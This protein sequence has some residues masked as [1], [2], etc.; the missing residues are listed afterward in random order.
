MATYNDLKTRAEFLVDDTIDNIAMWFNECLEDLSDISGFQKTLVFDKTESDST[1]YGGY[2]FSLPSDFIEVAEIV[3]LETNSTTIKANKTFTNKYALSAMS[4][5]TTELQ[6]YQVTQDE[7]DNRVLWVYPTFKNAIQVIFR[8]DAQLPKTTATL[9]GTPSLPEQYHK[10]LS[11]Y[12]ASRYFQNAQGE[13]EAKND[14]Y[15]EYLK[16]KQELQAY[17]ESKRQRYIRKQVD[18]KR[19]WW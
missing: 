9:S 7:S 2:H 17:T 12:A 11:L 19:V 16:G 13:L 15:A 4:Y 14:Y 1:K 3:L 5:P 6:G 8:Y 10:L 18:V